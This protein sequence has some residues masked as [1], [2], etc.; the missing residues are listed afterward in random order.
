MKGMKIIL[1]DEGIISIE[2]PHLLNL[3]KNNQ[4]DTIYHEHFSYIGLLTLQK[5][6]DSVDLEIIDV[7][8]I[9]THGGSLRVYL[10]HKN[11]I[12]PSKNVKDLISKEKEY[13]LNKMEA[14][15]D[16]QKEQH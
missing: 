9:K 14:F 15:L 16:F 13:K 2:F 12:A 7:E 10:T 1:S 5:I 11:K 6:S 3:I 4:F 8:E